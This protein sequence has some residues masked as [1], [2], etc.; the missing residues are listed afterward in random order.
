MIN[1]N[2]LT[3]IKDGK[4]ISINCFKPK[5]GVKCNCICP[6]CGE[7]VRS[8]VTGKDSSELKINYAN[9][10]S[11]VNENSKC[12]GGYKETLLHLYAKELIK[13]SSEL[14]VPSE[15]YHNPNILKYVEVKLE[16][17]FPVE[18]YKQYRPDIL[19]TTTDGEKVAVEIYV[20][21]DLSEEK[22]QLYKKSKL[23]CL[24]IDLSQFYYDDFETSKPEI[25]KA[26]F[27]YEESK[28]TKKWV[29]PIVLNELDEKSIHNN[30][31]KSSAES[32]GC[33]IAII[34]FLLLFISNIG[35]KSKKQ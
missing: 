12:S 25:E 3:A 16:H 9:R 8:N 17:A 6:E 10:F 28:E 18:E 19:L 20:T 1:K 14:Y 33:I 22:I 24:R 5:D 35:N 4:Y 2:F 13:K 11:H 26:I 27:G 31:P 23:K 29:W 30:K 7:K 34:V 15:R 21:N 32:Q